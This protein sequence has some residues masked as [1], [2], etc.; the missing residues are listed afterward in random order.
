MAPPGQTGFRP[1]KPLV[2]AAQLTV[3]ELYLTAVH[4]FASGLEVP[5]QA[6]F[7]PADLP[8]DGEF[9]E[10]MGMV[11]CRIDG[12]DAGPASYV[13]SMV[14][15]EPSAHLKEA[16]AIKWV[17]MLSPERVL[18]ILKAARALIAGTD[19]GS[20]GDAAAAAA[21]AGRAASPLLPFVIVTV[22]GFVD[23]PV[24][25][26]TQEHGFLNSG[27]NSYSYVLFPDDGR[28]WLY[29]AVG[30]HDMFSL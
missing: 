25:W 8:D 5:A 4:N 1:G 10:W 27:D 17:G 3:V 15:P 6:Y 28:Y 24:S 18:A 16:V 22:W 9:Y 11:A 30:P 20:D 7:D 14:C 21:A 29:T 12:A 19:K 23:A 26:G 2:S 13:S